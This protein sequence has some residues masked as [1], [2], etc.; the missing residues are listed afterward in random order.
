MVLHVYHSWMLSH[1]IKKNSHHYCA[2][3]GELIFNSLKGMAGHFFKIISVDVYIA[4]II[5]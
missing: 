3:H 5:T 2:V 1:V 4:F